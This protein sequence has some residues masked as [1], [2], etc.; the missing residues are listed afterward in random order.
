MRVLVTGGTGAV[1]RMAVARLVEHGH[2]V[3]VIGRRAGMEID[4][5]AYRQCDIGNFACITECVQ[6][7]E[8]IVHL[9]A[10]PNPSKGT[11]EEI[12]HANCTGTFNVYQA[13]ANAGIKRIISAS[14]INA[15][16]FNFGIKRFPLR[17]F[18]MDEEHPSFTT[19]PYSFSKQVMEEIGAYFWRR[20]GISSL[21][22]RLPGVYELTP[23][24]E[25]RMRAFRTAA[26]QQYEEL[27][28][29]PEAQRSTIVVGIIAQH[30]SLRAERAFE[31]PD[32]FTTLREL[33]YARVMFGYSNFWASI[34]ARDS[35]QCIEKGLLADFEGCHPVYVNDDHNSAGIPTERLVEWFY[36]D[37]PLKRPLVG[38]ET[39]VSIDKVRDLV[40]FEPEY[41][42]SRWFGS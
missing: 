2:D 3:T 41:S 30:D 25:E 17:Y 39:L 37:V 5:A 20:E 28:A 36:P 7:M 34:D 29:M 32:N 40:G 31:V 24:R 33:P 6:G 35:A 15:F 11:S 26:K 42:V 38:M 21:F 14:S 23:E 8:G 19:D 10:I 16:G 9:A 13:A 18:P 12:F 22:L 4:G 1:G 27:L